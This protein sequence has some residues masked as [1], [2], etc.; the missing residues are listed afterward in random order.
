MHIGKLRH[1]VTIQSPSNATDPFSAPGTWTTVIT[2]WASIDSASPRDVYNAGLQNMRVSHVVT[3]RYP[4]AA[5]VI[6]A[7]YQ[8]H[9][10][11]RTFVLQ[12][13]ITNPEERNV[14]LQL[15]AWEINPA[16]GGVSD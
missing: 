11:N 16:E 5:Y 6:N 9:Y 15:L 2:M 12:Q 4:G 8:I 3:L 10:K 14:L 1:R 7:G 13:G